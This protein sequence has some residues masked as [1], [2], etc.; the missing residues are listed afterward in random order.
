MAAAF[1]M[2]VLQVLGGCG[3]SPMY[4]LAGLLADF[5]EIFPATET[6]Q[7]MKIIQAMGIV[8]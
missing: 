5:V 7:I 1:A 6:P 4:H 3:V 2:K 8:K